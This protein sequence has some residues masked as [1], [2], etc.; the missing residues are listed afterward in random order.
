MADRYEATRSPDET[1][2]EWVTGT[3]FPLKTWRWHGWME[4]P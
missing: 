4:Q 1:D 3:L 2:D